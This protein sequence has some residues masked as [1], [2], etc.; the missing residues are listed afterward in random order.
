MINKLNAHKASLINAISLI[1]IGGFGYLQ[2]ETPSPTALIPVVVGVLLIAM[3]KGVKDENKIIAH[4]A[5]LLTF[6]ML[7]GLAM[8]LMG[9]VKRGDTQGTIRVIVMIFTTIGALFYFVKSFID[10]RKSRESS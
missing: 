2:S 3:N 6:I 5:V 1:L 9:S 8:P 7:L 4:I 10:A